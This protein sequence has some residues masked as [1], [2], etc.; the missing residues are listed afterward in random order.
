[1]PSPS[2]D[3]INSL[4]D[5]DAIAVP[6]FDT[7]VADDIVALRAMLPNWAGYDQPD[8][9][10]YKMIEYYND[11]DIA[12]VIEFNERWRQTLLAFAT[13]ENLDKVAVG[14]GERR[15]SP[16]ESDDALRLRCVESRRA[17]SLGKVS[18]I[19]L[20][21]HEIV[22]NPSFGIDRV[23]DVA[24]DQPINLQD[25]SLYFTTD[26]L[27]IPSVL[28]ISRMQEWFDNALDD[29]NDGIGYTITVKQPRIVDYAL[30]I[31][32]EYRSAD[33]DR[34]TLESTVR[35]NMENFIRSKS[36]L[37]RQINNSGIHDAG[38]I[39]GGT[40]NVIIDLFVRT[41]GQS[42]G[43]VW[44]TNSGSG[45]TSAPRVT[46]SNPSRGGASA[47]ASGHTEIKDG[48]V[49][50]VIV[51]RG[52]QFYTSTPTVTIEGPGEGLGATATAQAVLGTAVEELPDS[53]DI[54][55]RCNTGSDLFIRMEAI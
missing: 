22:Q 37:K 48:R 46:F 31:V 33:V 10:S 21:A 32:V 19:R 39:L 53:E 43:D 28:D 51:D 36:L 18:A 20:A 45:Y 30:G 25:F 12:R 4:D 8:S 29:R 54:M 3:Y 11:K 9:A 44:L 49:T 1:M 47:A 7:A 38:Y 17:G 16:L 41:G 42:V 2:L 14:Y 26:A 5:T 52:G 23:Y 24:V 50:N 6:D 13:G 40:V 34:T 55:Y 15:I 27:T 35:T